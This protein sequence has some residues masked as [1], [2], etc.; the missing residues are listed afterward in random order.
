M[1]TIASLIVAAAAGAALAQPASFLDIG[2]LTGDVVLSGSSN[3][4]QWFRF[5]I[6][7]DA[8]APTYLD[9]TS[10]GSIIPDTGG[11]ADTELALFNAAGDFLSTDDDDGLQFRS[12]LSFGAGSGL[13]LGDAF[14]LGG[15]GIANGND[16]NLAA[17]T[18]WL[19]LVDW[20]HTFSNGFGVTPVPGT[21]VAPHNWQLSVYT[22]IVPAPGS[23]ALLGLGGLVATRRRR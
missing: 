7:Q 23:L 21:Q 12:T 20:D 11:N 1:K 9:L 3:G 16:G 14:D 13:L 4:V 15:D 22:N 2:S 18:Y 10:N 8:I 19:A 5:S 6:A 17:G